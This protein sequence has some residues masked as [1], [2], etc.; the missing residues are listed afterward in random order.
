MK[1]RTLE[2]LEKT[3]ENLKKENVTVTNPVKAYHLGAPGTGVPHGD[4]LI[5]FGVLGDG[6]DIHREHISEAFA[7]FAEL[8]AILCDWARLQ[9]NGLPASIENVHLYEMFPAS[10]HYDQGWAEIDDNGN[11]IAYDRSG[12]L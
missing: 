8:R 2:N 4:W 7:T 3:L 12:I 10:E 9:H 5:T 6:N 1:N 11:P